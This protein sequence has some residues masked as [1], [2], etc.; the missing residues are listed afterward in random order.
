MSV[1]LKPCTWLICFLVLQYLIGCDSHSD[2]QEKK[3]VMNTDLV[4]LQR[5]IKLPADVE[6]CEWQTGEF[7]PGG[8]WWLAATLRIR[9]DDLSKFLPGQPNR[10]LVELPSTLRFDSSFAALKSVPSTGVAGSNRISFIADVYPV[11]PYESSPLLN[12]KAIKLSEHV[13]F[14]LLWT[15]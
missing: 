12:G 3:A 6:S 2:P 1:R 10:E 15:L 14:V 5:L 8:D 7:V 9:S 13:V 11:T 4:A